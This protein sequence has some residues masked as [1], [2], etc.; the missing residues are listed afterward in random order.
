MGRVLGVL[1]EVV[2][3]LRPWI[4]EHARQCGGFSQK[5]AGKGAKLAEIFLKKDAES[6]NRQERLVV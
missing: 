5:F 4:G 2:H 1:V 6:A 3:H